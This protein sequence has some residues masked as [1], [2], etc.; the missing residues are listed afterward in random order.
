MMVGINEG[1]QG[2]DNNYCFTKS[3]MSGN[4]TTSGG[5]QSARLV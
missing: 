3:D 2:T 4:S 5:T 1:R